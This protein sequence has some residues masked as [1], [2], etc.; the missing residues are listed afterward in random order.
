MKKQ[1]HSIVP[2]A[3]LILEREGKYLLARRCGTGYRD[4]QYSLV[5]GHVEPGESFTQAIIREAQEEIGITLSEKDLSVVHVMQRKEIDPEFM[6][7][8]GNE[9]MDV[10]LR[11]RTWSGELVNREPHK[12]DELAW[13]SYDELPQTIVPYVRLMFE[14]IRKGIFYS[15]CGWGK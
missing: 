6:T 5:A 12:C 14:H 7:E 13:F 11:A 8:F 4:G 1:R 10:F 9:R 15:E 3:Y 2:A